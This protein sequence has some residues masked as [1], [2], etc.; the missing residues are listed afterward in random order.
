MYPCGEIIG[1]IGRHYPDADITGGDEEDPPM[2]LRNASTPN[3]YRKV[4]GS[5]PL[6]GQPQCRIV[7]QSLDPYLLRA[8]QLPLAATYIPAHPTLRPV[9]APRSASGNANDVRWASRRITSDLC[10][11]SLRR[12]RAAR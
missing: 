7:M 4:T 2:V 9:C 5:D 3:R 6:G 11:T 10:S 12:G 1:V 8:P